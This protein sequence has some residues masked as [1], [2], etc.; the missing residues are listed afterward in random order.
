MFD[1][2]KEKDYSKEVNPWL[3]IGSHVVSENVQ[4]KVINNN[5]SGVA[6]G[7]K[8]IAKV[9][10]NGE[11]HVII[12]GFEYTQKDERARHHRLLINRLEIVT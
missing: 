7:T 2:F 8:G 9:F 5:I 1:K 4:V 10:S 11:A 3:P 6:P 12:D